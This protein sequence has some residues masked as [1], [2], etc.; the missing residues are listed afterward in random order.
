MG[1]GSQLDGIVYPV[2]LLITVAELLVAVNR[3]DAD[4]IAWALAPRLVLKRHAAAAA[5]RNCGGHRRGGGMAALV[6]RDGVHAVA[7]HHIGPGIVAR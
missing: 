7:F 6:A 2:V 4:I 1:A 5:H 3:E